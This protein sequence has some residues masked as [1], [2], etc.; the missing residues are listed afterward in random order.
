M[1]AAARRSFPSDDLAGYR[2]GRPLEEAV[3]EAHARTYATAET[4]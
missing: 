2:Q 3:A 4:G 1:S